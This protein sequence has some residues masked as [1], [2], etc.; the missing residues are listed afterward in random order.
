LPYI[1]RYIQRQIRHRKIRSL[2]IQAKQLFD[3]KEYE[4]E[5]KILTKL[6]KINPI[7]QNYSLRGSIHSKLHKYKEATADFT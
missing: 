4:D 2:C 1:L 3:N 5:L 7:S 6:I